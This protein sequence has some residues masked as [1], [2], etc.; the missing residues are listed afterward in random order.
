MIT[1]HAENRIQARLTGL[2]STTDIEYIDRLTNRYYQG[3][4][5]IRIKQFETAMVRGNS[6]GNCVTVVINDGNV[7]TA[8]LS[9][10]SQTWTDGQLVI[11]LV[12]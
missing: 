11:Q 4:F 1:K 7:K 8:M 12:D 9:Y 5:Y 2:I 6:Y 10:D 3:K